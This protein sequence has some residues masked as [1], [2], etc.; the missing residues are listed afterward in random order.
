MA[1][2]IPTTPKLRAGQKAYILFLSK[3]VHHPFG[4]CL[5]GLALAIVAED[6]ANRPPHWISRAGND[7]N[8]NFSRRNIA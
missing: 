8:R 4:A 6:R 2:A 3:P 1:T 7:F 5:R